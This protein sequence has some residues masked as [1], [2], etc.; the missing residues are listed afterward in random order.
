M[1]EDKVKRVPITTQLKDA[2]WNSAIGKV[3]NTVIEFP[4]RNMEHPP[5]LT[6]QL[7]AIRRDALTDI[8]DTVHQTF[9][10]QKEGP[11]QPGMPLNPTSQ[12]VTQDLGTANFQ[13]LLDQ[14]ASRGS[15][16]GPEQNRGM[17]R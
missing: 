9:F 11:G 6:G 13:N 10:G 7:D 3:L 8:R 17:S 2:F 16:H 4:S 14:F 5:S 15:V 12:M 1:A